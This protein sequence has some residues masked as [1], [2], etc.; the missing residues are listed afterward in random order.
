[1]QGCKPRDP[2]RAP[3]SRRNT[4]IS[5][6]ADT[7]ALRAGIYIAAQQV[8][9]ICLPP[10]Q[11]SPSTRTT[12]A[13]PV[14]LPESGCQLNSTDP[15]PTR[16][17]AIIQQDD[18]HAPCTLY[19]KPWTAV[20][21]KQQ[22]DASRHATCPQTGLSPH[23]VYT[24]EASTVPHA[25]LARRVGDSLPPSG[26]QADTRRAS[27]SPSSPSSSPSS[28]SSPHL[29]SQT[30]VQGR[31]HNVHLAKQPP[32]DREPA[33]AHAKTNQTSTHLIDERWVP[34]TPDQHLEIPLVSREK[35]NTA[36][37]MTRIEHVQR[38]QPKLHPTRGCTQHETGKPQHPQPP[39]DTAAA[40]RGPRKPSPSCSGGKPC[41]G[42]PKKKKYYN[43]VFNG[44][45]NRRNT[46]FSSVYS[47]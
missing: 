6:S 28:P 9:V 36:S 5:S 8:L 19:L 21:G 13:L 23:L 37:N 20:Q 41:C 24:P 1:V 47:R 35:K 26:Q 42:G 16:Q 46:G 40:R 17:L 12:R 27:S 33:L 3:D 15:T 44:T 31:L 43:K 32:F 29:H 11:V 7:H 25:M 45:K 30:N 22:F 10:P 14:H 38:N 18:C 2:G 4:S 34:V 39:T